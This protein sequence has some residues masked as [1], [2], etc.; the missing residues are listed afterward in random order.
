MIAAAARRNREHVA[1]GR[2]RLITS[3]V[4]DADLGEAVFD[5][6][7]AFNVSL[8]WTPPGR[9]LETVAELLAPGGRLYVFHQAPGSGKNPVIERRSRAL[10]AHHGFQVTAGLTA[11]SSPAE[12]LCLIAR[13]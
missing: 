12:S 8:F 4:V 13:R 9:G 3:T 6:I 5:K 10:L 11:A 1:A 2:V 7:Y